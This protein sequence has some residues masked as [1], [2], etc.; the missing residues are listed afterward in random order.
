MSASSRHDVQDLATFR[1]PAH[2]RGRSA[3]VVQLW[4]LVQAVLFHPSPQFLYGWR[5]GLLRLFGAKIG[6]NVIIRPSVRVTYPWKLEIGD[7]SWVGDFV[8]LYTL[9]EIKIGDNAVVSQY[10][11]LCTGSHDMR[12]PSFDIYAKPIVVEDEA[13]I[14]SGVFVHPG[15]T[16][17][18]CSVVGARSVLSKDTE[19]FGVYA[20]YPAER[21]GTRAMRQTAS[22][23]P[24]SDGTPQ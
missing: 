16:V 3:L 22:G 23:A 11:Y 6:K 15:V 18:R 12:S 24:A 13:W 1:L 17:A 9:G 20:G 7:N 5:N 19:P 8:E 2:F 4:W 14:A 10:T 21:V